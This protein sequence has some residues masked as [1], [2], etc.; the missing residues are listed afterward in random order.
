MLDANR[1]RAIA[2]G[3]HHFIRHGGIGVSRAGSSSSCLQCF[4]NFNLSKKV[5]SVDVFF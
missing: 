2:S 3:V 4:Q 1:R 5:L